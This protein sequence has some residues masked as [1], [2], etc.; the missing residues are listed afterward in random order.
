MP[1]I[2]GQHESCDVRVSNDPYVSS[3][4]C[5]VRRDEHGCIWVHD[6]GSLNGTR[7]ERDGI[8]YRVYGPPGWRMRPGDTLWVGRTPIRWNPEATR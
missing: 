5:A 2:V 3:R 8:K 1:M 6:L 7:V 4:H